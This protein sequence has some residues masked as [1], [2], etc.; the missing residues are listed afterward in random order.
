MIERSLVQEKNGSSPAV[1]R[2]TPSLETGSANGN[3]AHCWQFCKTSCM[4]YSKKW[5][6]Y[7]RYFLAFGV[8]IF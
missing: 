7:A 4:E 3:R 1:G 5:A 6:R 8:F 2:R